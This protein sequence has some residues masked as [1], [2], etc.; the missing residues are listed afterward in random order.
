MVGR[1]LRL[2]PMGR[3]GPAAAVALPRDWCVCAPVGAVPDFAQKGSAGRS[4]GAPAGAVI[5]RAESDAVLVALEN[6]HDRAAFTPPA[7]TR[8]LGRI[9]VVA[10]IGQRADAD[11]S[12]LLDSLTALRDAGCAPTRWNA[13]PNALTFELAP[14][15]SDRAVRALHDRLILAPKGDGH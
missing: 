2:D 13:T 1:Q 11:G 4:L 8:T 5:R 7:G 12:M 6:W 14:A 9:A 15:L 10:V 3:M